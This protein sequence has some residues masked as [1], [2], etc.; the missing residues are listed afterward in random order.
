MDESRPVESYGDL[1]LQ[2]QRFIADDTED[3]KLLT[4]A[5]ALE[6]IKSEWGK[7]TNSYIEQLLKKFER[8]KR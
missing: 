7:L 4:G 3:L 1:A 6:A 2:F 5:E 8:I